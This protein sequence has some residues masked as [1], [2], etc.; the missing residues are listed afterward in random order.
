M[1]DGPL[2]AKGGAGT[3]LANKLGR[4]VHIL[5]DKL[6]LDD[7]VLVILC[8]FFQNLLDPGLHTAID[9]GAFIIVDP[10]R[11]VLSKSVG[12][13]ADFVG[14]VARAPEILL[15]SESN[16]ILFPVTVGIIL[17][18]SIEDL[19]EIL[20]GIGLRKAH[21][22][23]PLLVDEKRMHRLNGW[24]HLR[25]TVQFPVDGGYVEGK[26][27]VHRHLLS[28]LIRGIFLPRTGHRLEQTGFHQ[29]IQL[30]YVNVH[31]VGEITARH[32]QTDPLRILIPRWSQK[33]ILDVNVELF[34]V[35][36][37][38]RTILELILRPPA[39]RRHHRHMHRFRVSPKRTR[40]LHGPG[41]RCGRCL[42]Y[43][44]CLRRR[45]RFWRR[46]LCRSTGRGRGNLLFHL[47]R[48]RARRQH[49]SGRCYPQNL[50][51]LATRHLSV[52]LSFSPLCKRIPRV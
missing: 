45:R 40:G 19:F 15:E 5:H 2:N 11:R 24:L 37:D 48:R 12:H 4:L 1:K 34:F 52:H 8:Q 26:R 29:L 44:R 25:N 23:D 39:K 3:M 30:Y 27:T 43:G 35:E 42:R 10:R 9:Y 7:A 31:H 14:G 46:L 33:C 22:L 18:E 20:P 13:T 6:A 32:S 50:Q 41:C 38:P 49:R 36:L 47:C 21:I 16:V 51:Q 17:H 28:G